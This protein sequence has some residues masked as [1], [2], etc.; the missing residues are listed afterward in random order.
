MRVSVVKSDK[1]VVVDGKAYGNL[2]MSSVPAD[3]VAMQWYGTYGELEHAEVDGVKPPN[4]RV[5]SM[6]NF[7]PLVNAWQV[8]AD[9]EANYVDPEPVITLEDKAKLARLD[10]DELLRACDWTQ[11][12]DIPEATRLLW[13]PYRQALRDITLQAGF[14]ETI[15]WPVAP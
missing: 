4:T 12:N 1:F 2:D 7:L 6:D 8:A 5:T 13:Q 3:V 11:L 10:R 9:A 14:P 15:D